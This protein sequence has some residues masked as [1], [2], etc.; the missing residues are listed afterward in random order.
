M[1]ITVK[2]DHDINLDCHPSSIVTSLD[3]RD[4]AL[5]LYR[6]LQSSVN[7]AHEESKA[8][9]SATYSINN[10]APIIQ[11]LERFQSALTELMA[12]YVGLQHELLFATRLK[13]LGG[14]Q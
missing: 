6:I 12:Y 5:K 13:E 7:L 4:Q 3:E 1:K 11:Q 14:E 8:L 9:E 2:T 10:L